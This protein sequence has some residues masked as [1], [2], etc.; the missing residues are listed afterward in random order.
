MH[1]Q[2]WQRGYFF[3]HINACLG[4]LGWVGESL[5]RNNV[6]PYKWGLTYNR[7]QTAIKIYYY[8]LLLLCLKFF[9]SDKTSYK[10]IIHSLFLKLNYYNL[11]LLLFLV[12]SIFPIVKYAHRRRLRWCK[13]Y[14]KVRMQNPRIWTKI[15]VNGKKWAVLKRRTGSGKRGGGIGKR[16]GGIRKR[17][18]GKSKD[19]KL[20]WTLA[21][22]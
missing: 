4:W 7:N 12:S 6:S 18:N 10:K 5:S 1:C 14:K 17:E 3:S 16:G 22:Q 21:Y 19:Q 20:T 2:L 9:I 8:T 15:V 13:M 11:S